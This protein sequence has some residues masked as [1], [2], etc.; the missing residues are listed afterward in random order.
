[1]GR[2]K[3]LITNE[4]GTKIIVTMVKPKTAALIIAAA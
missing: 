3:R 1:M 2:A 4:S